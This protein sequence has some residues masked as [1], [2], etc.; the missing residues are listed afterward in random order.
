MSIFASVR[1]TISSVS[2]FFWYK[3]YQEEREAA[4]YAWHLYNKQGQHQEKVLLATERYLEEVL[5]GKR[6]LCKETWL[7]YKTWYIDFP[8]GD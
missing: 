2:P 5:D 4:D 3:R 7:A 8:L 1:A 6:P